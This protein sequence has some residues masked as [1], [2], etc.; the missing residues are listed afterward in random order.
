MRILVKLFGPLE[1]FRPFMIPLP[2]EVQGHPYAPHPI[3]AESDD[4]STYEV[5]WEQRQ[6]AISAL[7]CL[8]RIPN[9]VVTWAHE[10]PHPAN[11]R[12]SF[13]RV[14]G[15]S[16]SNFPPRDELTNTQ[17]H[18]AP[19]TPSRSEVVHRRPTGT[20][21]AGVQRPDY[22]RTPV[23]MVKNIASPM[24][25]NKVAAMVSQT[26]IH[27]RSSHDNVRNTPASEDF[28][29]LPGAITDEREG[30]AVHAAG[31]GG[32]SKYENEQDRVSVTSP[33]AVLPEVD[34]SDISEASMDGGE[35]AIN[36]ST[37]VAPALSLRESVTPPST[38]APL[39]DQVESEQA[40]SSV[41]GVDT[42][43]VAPLSPETPSLIHHSPSRSP[44]SVDITPSSSV[45]PITPSPLL[46]S[47]RPLAQ[48][49]VEF[50]NYKERV[51]AEKAAATQEQQGI[52]TNVDGAPVTD[53]IFVG[54]L[55]LSY[56]WTEDKIKDTF[57]VYGKI[58]GV[59]L[60][61]K[62][63]DYVGHSFIKFAKPSDM[64]KA[65][66][67]EVSSQKQVRHAWVSLKCV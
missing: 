59:R 10:H 35:G 46:R 40:H 19:S 50:A 66:A 30:A 32:T 1:I 60:I 15:M 65:I 20:P 53:S 21:V 37:E 51:A 6:D 47:S 39:S 63:L 5:K 23:N 14:H 28:P 49:S 3:R 67:G 61:F 57:S 7:Y 55:D 24:P 8:N 54:G 52:H 2:E 22:E 12:D 31:T 17:S 4:P 13:S 18:P 26:P 64:A 27:P 62:N 45:M 58:L 29:P 48:Q 36:I 43:D 34:A 9:L 42:P 16:S 33:Y 11:Y 56:G 41:A 38:M 44:T 25:Y